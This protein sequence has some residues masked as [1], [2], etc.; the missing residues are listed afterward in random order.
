VLVSYPYIPLLCAFA[1]ADATASAAMDVDGEDDAELRAAMALSMA[2]DATPV[3]AGIPLN[4]RG[5]YELYGVVTH[6]GRASNS[7]HYM[8]WVKQDAKGAAADDWVCFDDDHASACKEED[9]ITKLRGGGDYHMAYMLFYR[10]K[11]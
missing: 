6:K 4:F 11:E 9:V 7:G 2:E 3:G 5:I 8:G 10:V 1:G